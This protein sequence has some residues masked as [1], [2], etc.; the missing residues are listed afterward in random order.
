M[1][2]YKGNVSA[3]NGPG[4]RVRVRKNRQYFTYEIRRS[5]RSHALLFVESNV[6]AGGM[7]HVCFF[8]NRFFDGRVKNIV[9][10]THTDGGI[11]LLCFS[12]FTAQ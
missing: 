12:G 1:L 8:F 9:A 6:F 3:L 7:I 5:T 2:K 11:L 10:L 4:R